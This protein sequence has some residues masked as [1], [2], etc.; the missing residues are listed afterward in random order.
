MAMS[1][2]DGILIASVIP[3]NF[4]N[5]P[6]IG[7]D[8]ANGTGSFIVFA[9]GGGGS[10][11]SNE[12]GQLNGNPAMFREMRPGTSGLFGKCVQLKNKGPHFRGAVILATQLELGTSGGTGG[13]TDCVLVQAAAGFRFLATADSVE[14]V[15]C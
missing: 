14:E 12:G 15:A 6:P 11:V 4:I 8:I 10:A 3:T 9:A 13:L 1:A 2:G 5:T 7:G